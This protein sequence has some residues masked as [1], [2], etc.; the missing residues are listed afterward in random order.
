MLDAVRS[1]LSFSSFLPLEL[2]LLLLDFPGTQLVGFFDFHNFIFL[3]D[4]VQNFSLFFP[5]NFQVFQ[6]SITLFISQH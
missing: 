5:L 1:N 2:S 4:F 6:F 3:R